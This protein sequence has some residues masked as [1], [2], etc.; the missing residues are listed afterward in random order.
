LLGV[1]GGLREQPVA[2]TPGAAGGDEEPAAVTPPAWEH[3]PAGIAT[4]LQG[5][6]SLKLMRALGSGSNGSS[7]NSGG[8][9]S[10]GSGDR[11]AQ[12]AGRP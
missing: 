4:L 6:L 5:A 3:A 7:S 12:P 9:G 2:A 8:G 11:E 10:G 1:F